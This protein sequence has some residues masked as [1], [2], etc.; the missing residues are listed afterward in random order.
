MIL[1]DILSE[2]DLKFLVDNN[3]DINK[4]YITKEDFNELF[5]ILFK[6]SFEDIEQGE[7]IYDSI[8]DTNEY[9]LIKGSDISD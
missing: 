5:N 6:I 9:K 4:K 2:Y 1:K 7:R 8:K 3:V